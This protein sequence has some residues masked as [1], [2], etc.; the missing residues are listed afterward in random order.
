MFPSDF[1]QKYIANSVKK[2]SLLMHDGRVIEYPQ[3]KNK[4]K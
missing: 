4:Q 1:E 3:A 2:N